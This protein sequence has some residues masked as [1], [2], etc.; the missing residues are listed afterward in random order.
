MDGESN[1]RVQNIN[2]YH[3]AGDRSNISQNVTKYQQ[4]LYVITIIIWKHHVTLIQISTNKYKH[5]W[6]CLS[7]FVN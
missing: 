3:A 5:A 4:I 1:G 2:T 6:Y 7:I